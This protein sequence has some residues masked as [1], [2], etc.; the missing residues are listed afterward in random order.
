MFEEVGNKIKGLA[1]FLTVSGIIISCI[2][3]FVLW[4]ILTWWIG[5]LVIVFGSLVFW[6]FSLFLYGFGQLVE[7]SD[8]IAKDTATTAK[9]TRAT[10]EA[11]KSILAAME[12]KPDNK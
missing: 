1:K 10:A 11:A 12:K 9:N 4:A 8:T 2:V 3:G 7:N 5:L 6:I